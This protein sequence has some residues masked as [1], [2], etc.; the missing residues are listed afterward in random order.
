VHGAEQVDRGVLVGDQIALFDG[1]PLD[2]QLAFL[3]QT[4]E[5]M[6][7]AASTLDAMVAEWLEGDAVQLAALLNAELT[8]PVLY[9][10]LLTSR[11]AKWAG[12]IENRLAQPGTVFIAVGAGHSRAGSALQPASHSAPASATIRRITAKCASPGRRAP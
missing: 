10:R 3:D 7:V 6:P 8:D 11:N 1:M 9:D 5:A 2:A 4:V 12:W